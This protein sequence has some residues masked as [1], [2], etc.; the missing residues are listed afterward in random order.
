MGVGGA[1]WS[2]SQTRQDRHLEVHRV[3]NEESSF[4][5][6]LSSVRESS[7]REGESPTVGLVGL[8]GGEGQESIGSLRVVKRTRGVRTLDRSKTLKLRAHGLSEVAFG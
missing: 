1:L 3:H 8:E 4:G 7:W 5:C 2:S 6:L